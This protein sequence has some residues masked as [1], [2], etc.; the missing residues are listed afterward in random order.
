MQTLK[1]MS[2]TLLILV[3][4]SLGSSAGEIRKGAAIQVKPNSIWFEDAA[5]LTQ[6]QQLKKSR[7]SKALVSYQDRVL[8]SRDAWQFTSE[9]TVEILSHN[10]R[11]NQVNVEMKTP[12][13]MLGTTWWL[14]AK[15]DRSAASPRSVTMCQKRKWQVSAS[16][17]LRYHSP[18][19]KPR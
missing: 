2:L 5:K 13:R 17:L 11:Q 7:N 4:L 6:W 10:P 15:S 3:A 12:G 18:R 14:D 8:S 1:S 19:E 16:V 9:L